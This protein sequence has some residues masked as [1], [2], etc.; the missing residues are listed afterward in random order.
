MAVVRRRSQR[1]ERGRIQVRH[2]AAR[3]KLNM[4]DPFRLKT[5]RK[6]HNAPMW[7]PSGGPDQLGQERGPRVLS[8]LREEGERPPSRMKIAGIIGCAGLACA[9]KRLPL[10]SGHRRQPGTGGFTSYQFEPH[11]AHLLVSSSVIRL[12][13]STG[14]TA[15][16]VNKDPRYV[17]IPATEPGEPLTEGKT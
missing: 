17:R 1:M 7:V 13:D 3:V 5:Y 14:A 4:T 10:T 2:H 15:S 8:G 16:V 11:L 12:A 9:T 6:A